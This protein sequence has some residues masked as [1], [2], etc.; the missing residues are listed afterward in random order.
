MMFIV[1][2]RGMLGKSLQRH[3]RQYE[4]SITD[5]PEVDI[6]D[7]HGVDQSLAAFRPLETAQAWS[8]FTKSF[9]E[10]QALRHG[11]GRVV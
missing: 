7:G 9:G 4:L 6:A 3:F 1:G 8:V 5:L 2:G 11:D 10:G